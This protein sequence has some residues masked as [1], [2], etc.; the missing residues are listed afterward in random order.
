MTAAA[1]TNA[2]PGTRVKNTGDIANLPFT[3]TITKT[4][5]DRW[6][7]F[8]DV[9]PD[10]AEGEIAEERRGIP[11]HAFPETGPGARWVLAAPGERRELHAG[12]SPDLSNVD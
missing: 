8:M 7:Q 2:A 5:S 4:W 3:G 12:F 1:T 10:V 6:G 9:L 11:C